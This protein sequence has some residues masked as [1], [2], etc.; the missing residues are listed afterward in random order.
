MSRYVRPNVLRIRQFDTAPPFEARLTSGGEPIDLTLAVAV[1]FSMSHRDGLADVRGEAGIIV[2]EEGSVQ[3]EW[4]D[5]DTDIP[6]V[7]DADLLVIWTNGRK[8]RYPSEGDITIEIR[9]AV[10]P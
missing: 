4:A 2:P 9:E 10:Y 1:H 3:Y 8:T 5:G 6:G 7:Y